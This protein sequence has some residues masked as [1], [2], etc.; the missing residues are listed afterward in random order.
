[1][2]CAGCLGYAKHHTCGKC[3]A[4]SDHLDYDQYDDSLPGSRG[5]LK[6]ETV[7]RK[8]RIWVISLFVEGWTLED[9]RRYQRWKK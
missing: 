5:Y 4:S 9:E 3:P 7:W 1:M 8:L 2:S 6:K